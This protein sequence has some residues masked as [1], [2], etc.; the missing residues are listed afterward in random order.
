MP[1]PS[2]ET[3]MTALFNTLIASV[4]TN[5]TAN[6]NLNS[7]TLGN[8]SITA[9]LFAGLPVFGPGIPRGA[10]I[11]TLAPL[12]ISLP[13][14]AAAGPVP[15][16]TG[17]L[18]FSRRF[19]FWTQVSAQPALF[20]R[21]GDE[22]QQYSEIILPR[23]TLRAEVWIYSKAG[24]NPDIVPVTA[25]NNLL[26]AVDAAFAP[27]DPQTGRFTLGGLV[28]WCRREGKI[29]KDPGDAGGQAIAVA[30]VEITVP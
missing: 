16:T 27:D 18:T 29:I 12:T 14:T 11:Q 25:L 24:E 15:L 20:L 7:V 4:Q 2:R 5:F 23:Q 22:D 13:A 10:V 8:P 9:G 3:V 26:D 6:T 19:Q 17:F 1:R 30:D 21:D 28:E